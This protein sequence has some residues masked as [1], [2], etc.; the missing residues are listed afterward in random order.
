[1]ERRY[2]KR[3]DYLARWARIAT[4]IGVGVKQVEGVLVELYVVQKLSAQMISEK[5]LEDTGVMVNARTIQRILKRKGVVRSGG[6]AFK[7]AV[8]QNR[9]PWRTGRAKNEVL[10]LSPELRMK[11]MKQDGLRCVVC[12]NTPPNCAL[13]VVRLVKVRDGGL[14]LKDNFQTVCRE[15]EKTI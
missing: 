2:D 1:M 11:I 6:E 13:V 12:G 14:N 3:F 10:S 5:L 7:L 4:K 9:V 15:C 8:S